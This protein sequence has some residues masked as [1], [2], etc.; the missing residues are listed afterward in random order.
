VCVVWRP[1]QSLGRRFALI[2][3]MFIS[4][5][6]VV[7]PWMTRNWLQFGSFQ[8]TQRGGVVLMMR[9]YYDRMNDIEYK[10][11]F[12]HLARGQ[13]LKELVGS[14]LGFSQND[15]ELGGRLQRL[16]RD[17]SASFA[18][19]DKKAEKEGRP[20]DAIS[21]YRAARAERNRLTK[22]FS[23]QGLANPSHAADQELQKR[24]IAEILANPLKHLKV[25]ILFLWQAMALG[26]FAF[27]A[28]WIMTLV[29]ILRNNALMMGIALLPVGALVF[30]SLTAH[31]AP[32]L[33]VPLIPNMIAAGVVLAVCIG[34]API[35]KLVPLVSRV[36][37][38]RTCVRGRVL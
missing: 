16:N 1:M 31:L 22:Y 23:E 12:Y 18:S 32:R 20:A 30:L 36:W 15:L 6:L 33:I 14:Y 19:S 2:S 26:T 5:A 28:I 8:V 17:R 37:H 13:A 10:G 4:M 21:F 29:G 35:T 9:A 34:E 24:A 7:V 25:A 38:R 27:I 11:A 3:L